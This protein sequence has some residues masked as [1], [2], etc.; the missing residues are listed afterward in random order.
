MFKK[1]FSPAIAILLLC[2]QA[3]SQGCVAIRNVAG[4][5]QFAALGY[6][7]TTDEWMM[8]INNRYF[9]ATQ[10]F[11]GKDN[12]TPADPNNGLSIYEY[13]MNLEL[14]KIL[15]KGW[16]LAIDL[17]VSSNTIVSKAEHASGVRHSTSDFGIGDLR[18]TAYKW[19]LNSDKPRKGNIQF[20]LGLKFP[21]G[22]YHSMDYFYYSKTDPTLKILSPV[23][24]AIQ[25]GDGGVGITTELNAFY[26]FNRSFSVFSNFFYLISPVDVNGVSNQI[27]GIPPN[28]VAVSTT[29][30]VNSVT[31]NYTL[32][33]GG[34]FTY[35]R[36]V[37][38][39]AARYEGAPA[40]DLLGK[41][42]GLR[43]VGHIF[44]LEPGVEYKF[45]RSFIYSFV[46]IPV[47]RETIQTVPDKRAVQITGVYTISGGDLASVVYFVGYAFTF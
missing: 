15:K 27:A 31:D 36:F 26:I 37:V 41:N 43:R 42:D 10:A 35:K 33:A 32:R 3:K 20:G 38:T 7:E 21:T 25:L 18:I 9:H 2:S 16:A 40:Y 29:A 28:P 8:N 30:D 1:I 11:K 14:S 44:S 39:A 22:N 4:F 34:N 24:V 13:T 12:V 17:P 46:T 5:G 47:S 45:K 6:K 19:L 23:N